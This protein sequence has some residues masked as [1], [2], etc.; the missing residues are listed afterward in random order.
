ML[1]WLK[2]LA[3]QLTAWDET[4]AVPQTGSN[5][6]FSVIKLHRQQEAALGLRAQGA[7]SYILMR[8]GDDGS[9]VCL[10]ALLTF[11]CSRLV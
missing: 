9:L 8:L 4:L 2:L 3:P 10:S 11:A 6:L 5:H 1:R 7:G